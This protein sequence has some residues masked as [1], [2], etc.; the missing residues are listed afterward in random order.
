MFR[1]AAL[2]LAILTAQQLTNPH[3]ALP[4]PTVSRAY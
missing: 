2:R 1:L 4:Q 3:E